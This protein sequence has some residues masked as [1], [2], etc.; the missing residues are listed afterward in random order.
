MGTESDLLFR[1]ALP[2]DLPA[3]LTIYDNARRFMRQ[4]GNKTQWPDGYPS[5]QILLHDINSQQMYVATDPTGR[6]ILAA[7][8]LIIGADP[9][10]AVIEEGRWIDDTSPYAT[11]HRLVST[12][13]RPRISDDCITFCRAIMPNLRIDT[14]RQNRPMLEAIERN[15]FKYCGIIYVDDGTPRL[16]F[17]TDNK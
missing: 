9:S 11:I 4:N 17:Q 12:G 6:R 8:S 1:H 14:H 13:V 10:Y 3:L 5:E 16:A 7:F 2:D 15:G